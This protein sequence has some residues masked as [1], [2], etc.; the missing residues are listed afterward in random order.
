MPD[1]AAGL[2]AELGKL[3]APLE[4]SLQTADGTSALFTELGLPLP[5]EV[6]TEP[7]VVRRGR[8][9]RDRD[10]ASP[11]HSPPRSSSPSPPATRSR[12]PPLSRSSHPRPRTRSRRPSTSRAR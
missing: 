2:V 6:R 9:G 11:A 5:A 1:T 12:S 10:L 7:Q 4:Q 8:R 3:L